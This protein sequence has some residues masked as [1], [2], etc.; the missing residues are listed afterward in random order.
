M[1]SGHVT[2]PGI[3]IALLAAPVAFAALLSVNYALVPWACYEQRAGVLHAASALAF[4]LGSL[5]A[6]QA[7]RAWREESSRED[8]SPRSGRRRFLAITALLLSL[9]FL[10][11]IVA[12]EIPNL[13]LE[14]C[15]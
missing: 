7:W 12:L 8:D 14:P 15:L 4:V 2:K 5:G 13:F 9:Y 6:W 10:L 3:W 1:T 11:A